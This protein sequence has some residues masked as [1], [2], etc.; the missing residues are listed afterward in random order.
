MIELRRIDHVCLRVADVDEAARRWSVQF[1]LTESRREDGRAYLRCAYEPYSLELVEGEPG[2]DHAGWELRRHVSLDDA[3]RHLEAHG[4]AHHRREGCIH[5]SDPD[6]YGIE[7]MA[8]RQEVDRRPAVARETTSLPGFHPR[9]LGHINVLTT[10]LDAQTAF[11]TSVLGMRV[12][13]RLLGAGNWLY[14]NSDHHSMALV[15]HDHVHF[16][17]LAFEF[18]DWGELRVAFD[19]LGQHGRWLV[20]GPLRHALAQNLCGYVRIPDERLIVECYCDMEQLEPD[21]EPRDWPDDA[22]SSNAWGILPPRSYFR[23]DDEA[24]RYEREGLEMRGHKLP[25]LEVTS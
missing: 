1:G 7:I 3:A 19:H 15:Q 12:S 10:D 8:H 23:F 16:H 9:K 17:H 24:I 13:D 22:R 20:W 5:L 2:F 25:P 4:V 14:V 11:Y 21:H 18:V 6:R